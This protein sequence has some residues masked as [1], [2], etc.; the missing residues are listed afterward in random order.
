MYSNI[1]CVKTITVFIPRS[2]GPA[3]EINS[4]SIGVSILTVML[5]ALYRCQL[6][7]VN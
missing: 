2:S 7:L 6:C 3:K 4:H 1:Q 5:F